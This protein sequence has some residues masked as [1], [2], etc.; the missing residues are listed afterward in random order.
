[1]YQWARRMSASASKKRP[2]WI[3]CGLFYRGFVLGGKIPKRLAYFFRPKYIRIGEQL[4][5][6]TPEQRTE[7]YK[8]EGLA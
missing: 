8:K 6:M 7:F 2:N 4:D 3:K 1:M 5:D